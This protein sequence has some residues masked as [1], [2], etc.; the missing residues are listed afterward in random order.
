MHWCNPCVDLPG[1][2][3]LATQEVAA[4]KAWRVYIH[5]KR[6]YYVER[7]SDGMHYNSWETKPQV[8]GALEARRG[9]QQ[10]RTCVHQAAFVKSAEI[11]V[12][13]QYGRDAKM[14]SRA[15]LIHSSRQK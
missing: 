9:C 1:S 7:L 11:T 14:N 5:S 10:V 2:A 3:A 6:P 13:V 4:I 15:A 8:C 12:C